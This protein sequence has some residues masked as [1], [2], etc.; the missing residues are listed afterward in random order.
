MTALARVLETLP[1][2]YAVAG[3]AVLPRLL[4]AFA[5][6][7]DVQLEDVDRMRLTHWVGFAYTLG[8]LARIAE[9]LGIDPLPGESLQ[10][11]R[12]RVLALAV[13]RLS[14]AVSP[15]DIR[16]FV[17]AYVSESERAL[18]STFV[19]GLR[20]F[21][22]NEAF[23]EQPEHPGY[24]PLQLVENPLRVR[25]SAT[26]EAQG[27]RVPYLQRWE[28]RNLGLS[29]AVARLAI[30]GQPQERTAV[31]VVV[32]LTTG[33]LIGY[34]G[35]LRVGQRLELEPAP[36]EPAEGRRATAL[37][38]GVDVTERIFSV[39]GFIPGVPFAPDDLDEEPLLPRLAR[40]SN[41]WLFLSVGLYD[42]RGL[43]RVFFA[44]ADEALREGVYDS[45]YFDHAVFPSGVVARLALEWTEVEPA[46]FQVRVPRC[47]VL[48]A[49]EIAGV[50]EGPA[51]ERLADGLRAAI[52]EIRAAG[53]RAEVLLDPFVETQPQRV[54]VTLPW[55]V[56]PSERGPSGEG[57][58]LA[59]GARFGE[60][61]LDRARF[62]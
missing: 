2:P 46:S 61:A 25:R 49:P 57:E 51:H 50:P 40:G 47:V 21:S 15:V 53:V 43:N 8:D 30:T 52:A 29:D 28:E 48:E 24:R 26:L 38:D 4:D 55:I 13:A 34:A 22:L 42:V 23:E 18:R 5:I 11:F 9:L 6:E 16:G 12:A 33:D 14:G 39:G 35:V 56:V 36:D 1:S 59:L 54:R 44:I 20:R 60:S 41:R 37:L 58:T 17:Y 32:N 3:D 7:L 31:P 62:E 19:P 10:S 27:G 45:T